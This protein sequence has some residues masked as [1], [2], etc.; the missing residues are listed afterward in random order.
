MVR[1][2]SDA[3]AGKLKH[4]AAPAMPT[5][6]IAVQ[7]STTQSAPAYH[8]SFNVMSLH[9]KGMMCKWPLPANL[10]TTIGANKRPREDVPE[11]NAP[12]TRRRY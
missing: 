6:V 9:D 3:A 7:S 5:P 12:N 1:D 2:V 8:A 4:V 11:D 10:R